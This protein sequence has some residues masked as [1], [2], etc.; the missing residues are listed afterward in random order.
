MTLMVEKFSS[1]AAGDNAPVLLLLHGWQADSRIWDGLLFDLRKTFAVWCID[2]PG[3]GRN[4]ALSCDTAEQ[5]IALI[6]SVL[7]EQT[8]VVGWSLGG[9][10]ALQ[11]AH[12]Y[13]EKCSALITFATNPSFVSRD[14][15]PGM[16]SEL[17]SVFLQSCEQNP[18]KTRQRFAGLQ[19][20]GDSGEKILLKWMREQP[21]AEWSATQ[22]INGLQWLCNL[23]GRQSL[24]KLTQPSLHIFGQ[25]DQLVPMMCAD[26]VLQL[27]PNASVETIKEAAHLPFITQAESVVASVL[28]FLRDNKIITDTAL[29][30]RDK[31]VVAKS[32]GRA[33]ES[34]DQVAS[35]Q[36]MSAEQLLNKLSDKSISTCLDVGCGTGWVTQ[37]L[38]KKLPNIDVFAMD[39]AEGMLNHA[40][41]NHPLANLHWL[42]GDAENLPVLAQSMDLVF[43]N[44]A[45]QWCE[46]PLA[47][48][49]EFTRVLK[50]GGE[51]VIATLGP[52]TLHELR[53]AWA[54]VD[55]AVHVNSFADKSVLHHAIDR[56]GLQIVDWQ[57]QISQPCYVQ[58]V[59][60]LQELKL[61]GAHNV[62]A[63]RPRG[64]TGRARLK[65]LQ[66]S[67][68]RN[69]N[70]L[71]PAT[72]QLWFMRLR[73]PL[74]DI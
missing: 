7:P 53:D 36:R 17:F 11:L 41:H 24:A 15:W 51:I 37:N 19:A 70:E 16:S 44:L 26:A 10:L 74:L 68:Q 54:L 27:N 3:C 12:D 59:E 50:P 30:H 71:Y 58:L 63:G 66:D 18:E 56:S 32:F 22:L 9:N 62:N 43:S 25:Y 64:L 47:L 57:E 35:L 72:W 34:Y 39:L 29:T 45:I 1:T 69:D 21:L 52:Q 8:I 61:L 40:R 65:Q 14:T 2:L 42:C 28:V 55:A 33:A 60:L 67:Y 38:A 46:N 73:K 13:S 49:A 23:D 4:S 31:M 48:F 6:A 20:K 5:A